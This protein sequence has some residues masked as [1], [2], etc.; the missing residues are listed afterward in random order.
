MNGSYTS[1]QVLKFTWEDHLEYSALQNAVKEIKQIAT[2]INEKVRESE[3]VNAIMQLQN[4]VIGLENKALVKPGRTLV[5]EGLSVAT[6]ETNTSTGQLVIMVNKGETQKPRVIFLFNDILLWCK[7]RMFGN[8]YEFVKVDYL[9]D[10]TAS[11]CEDIAGRPAFTIVSLNSAAVTVA[12]VTPEEKLQWID[13]LNAPI[14][15]A[16]MYSV[17]QYCPHPTTKIM[18]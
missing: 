5:K 18:S 10:I 2:T 6:M 15:N 12:T 9:T 4:R 7:Q 16:G 13:L 3:N 17:T 8:S 14:E 1:K 11:N